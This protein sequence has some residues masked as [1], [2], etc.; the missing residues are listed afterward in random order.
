[1]EDCHGR[2]MK[3]T[4]KAIARILLLY[5]VYGIVGLIIVI[6]CAFWAL[7]EHFQAVRR[8][9]LL[10]EKAFCRKGHQR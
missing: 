8:D 9:Y 6:W 1:M 5:P 10:E 3:A 7:C 2:K 4:V